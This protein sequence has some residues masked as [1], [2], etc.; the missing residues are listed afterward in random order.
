MKMNIQTRMGY[1]LIMTPQ[2][3]QAIKLLQMPRVEMEQFIQ[4]SLLENPVLEE[5]DANQ[6]N[7]SDEEQISDLES[8]SLNSE[9]EKDFLENPDA[10]Y[11]VESYNIDSY[12]YQQINNKGS[13]SEN[14]RNILETT[15][16]NKITLTEHLIKQITQTDFDSNEVI[17]LSYLANNLHEDGYLDGS[18]R[19]LLASS[20]EV[21]AVIKKLKSKY[22]IDENFDATV[23]D[24]VYS[25]K[26]RINSLVQEKSNLFCPL[27]KIPNSAIH[28]FN[29]LLKK[30]QK[31][32]P[33]GIGS[34][35]LKECLTT[36]AE[37]FFGLD[38][39]ESKIL[40]NYSEYFSD[41]K[42]KKIAKKLDITVNDVM[43]TYQ[44]IKNLSLWPGDKFNKKNSIAI[45]SDVYVIKKNGEYIVKLNENFSKFKINPY[46]KNILKNY[47]NKKIR[48]NSI[49]SEQDFS[50][51]YILEKIR[52]GEWL[53]KN[54]EQRQRTIKKVTESIIKKQEKFFKYGKEYL[55]PMILK[56]V[57]DDIGMHESTVSR[58]SNQKYIYTPR[59]TFEIKF[60][61]SSG[62]EQK[63]GEIVSSLKIK[64]HIQ[65]IISKENRKKPYTDDYIAKK[66]SELKKI[67]VA[68]RTIAKY[69]E[70]LKILSSSKRKLLV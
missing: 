30:L 43:N 2:L 22:P 38:S 41:R 8:L 39:V 44:S 63:G 53:L 11:D 42:Y 58:I 50:N 21:F 57:A 56:D 13:D 67:Q 9:T 52:A 19:E 55:S 6:E 65:Q 25:A 32:D 40:N 18:L 62:I 64:E 5:I 35:S 3:Q 61:F 17:V 37:E 29:C 10:E 20:K 36:Q 48:Q 1:N 26:N 16:G 28:T 51:C 45:V 15:I 7:N 33:I 59:G 31:L 24:L 34:R 4:K 69:R 46:Y 12:D 47:R 27:E 70:S 54:I 14:K 60:F 66:L 68:R 49:N 23:G